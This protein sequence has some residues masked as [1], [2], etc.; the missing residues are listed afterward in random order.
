V[1]K[2]IFVRFGRAPIAAYTRV[3]AKNGMV[4]PVDVSKRAH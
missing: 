4:F 3:K 1:E 2:M